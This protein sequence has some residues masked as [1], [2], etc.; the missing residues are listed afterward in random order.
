MA[1]YAI[2]FKPSADKAL[3]RFPEPLQR[4]IVAATEKL[5]ENPRPASAVKLT[6]EVNLYRIRVGD[7]RIVLE[8]PSREVDRV[9]RSDRALQGCVSEIAPP[10]APAAAVAFLSSPWETGGFAA[11]PGQSNGGRN[12]I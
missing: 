11:F 12:E 3:K 8:N 5:A 4:R 6:D 7:Y 9:C 1:S 10:G 2:E